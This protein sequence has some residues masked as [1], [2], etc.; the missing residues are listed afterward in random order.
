ME[1]NTAVANKIVTAQVKITKPDGRV[2]IQDVELDEE[3]QQ[4]II[5]MSDEERANWSQSLL[6]EDA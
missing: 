2:I 5:A 4:R 3:S 1:G 6:K